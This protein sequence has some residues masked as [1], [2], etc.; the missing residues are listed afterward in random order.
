MSD[1]AKGY[2]RYCYIL[3]RNTGENMF[4]E[5]TRG[6]LVPTLDSYA[7]I[8]LEVFREMGGDRHPAITA[9]LATKRAS[10]LCGGPSPCLTHTFTIP[11]GADLPSHL[12]RAT[13]ERIADALQRLY[14]VVYRAPGAEQAGLD[15]LVAAILAAAEPQ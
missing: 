15:D 13:A 4:E 7:I 9:Y 5:L 2:L 10:L 14:L 8:P 6:Q 1:E 11:S 12:N 3:S